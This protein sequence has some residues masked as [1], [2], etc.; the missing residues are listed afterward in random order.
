MR[1]NYCEWRCDLS[2]NKFGFCKMYRLENG[3]IKERF[4]NNWSSI[5]ISRVE[6][7]PFYH[8]YPGSKSL[9]IGTF[10]CNFRCDYCSN[11]FVACQD[12]ETLQGQMLDL[13]PVKVIDTVEKTGC[14][15]IIFN[16]N[17]PAVSF[18]TLIELS[19]LAKKAGVPMGCLT[20]GYT[21]ESSTELL[22]S[23]FDF[24]NIGLKGFSSEF[25]KKYIGVKNVEPVLRNIRT[26]AKT[27]HV[28][29]TTPVIQGVNDNEL[30]DIAVFLSEIDPEIPWH[31]FR[32]L[33]EH[34]MK[35]SSYPSIDK[36]NDSL[37]FARNKLSYL[38][39]HNFVGSEWVN[40]V[41]PD[42]KNVVIE[43]FSLGCSGDRL[44]QFLCDGNRCTGCGHV[45]KLHG[46][47]ISWL[48]K[49][50]A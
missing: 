46:E 32:L 10:S 20:N 43:R 35:E 15:N 42:C 25:Y 21:T 1:C 48:Q 23:I 14:H 2:K 18:P 22:A 41:C 8:A 34:E 11:G 9:V 7:V 50:L 39:F 19:Q 16:V 29:V 37:E 12:P 26:F 30:N 3:G 4:P 44:D 13:A 36:I 45:I 28:E 6:S 33:P 31:V 47:K 40:T 17:E 5:S 38:Y 24:I 27:R 49:E